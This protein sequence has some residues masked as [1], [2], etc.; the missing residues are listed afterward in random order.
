MEADY[1]MYKRH[2]IKQNMVAYDA[3]RYNIINPQLSLIP[4]RKDYE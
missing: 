2:A 1:I 3:V 4:Q